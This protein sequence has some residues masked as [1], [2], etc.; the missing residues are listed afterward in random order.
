MRS[1]P[2]RTDRRRAPCRTRGTR[3]T[4]P[5]SAASP[6]AATGAPAARPAAQ[7][8]SAV[9]APAPGPGSPGSLTL[10]FVVDVAA[11]DDDLDRRDD[12]D[13]REQDPRERGGVT[14]LEEAERLL[15]D[16]DRVHQRRVGAV[17]R[18]GVEER[19]VHLIERLQ[20]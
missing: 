5:A 9:Q 6:R 2:T 19:R 7:A 16:V 10:P 11:A 17:G 14:E 18:R 8:E 13:D 1:R 3:S 4:T 15:E 20:A 12:G